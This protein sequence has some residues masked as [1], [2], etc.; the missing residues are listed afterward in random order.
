MNTKA[1]LFSFLLPGLMFGAED[2]TD[3][4]NVALQTILQRLTALEDQ[5]RQLLEQVQALRQEMAA[6]RSAP[7][8]ATGAE[9][10]ALP[11]SVEERVDVA[12]RRIE[13]QS[14]T[15]VE[16]AH[17]LP[18]SLTGMLLFNLFSNSRPNYDPTYPYTPTGPSS[19]GGTLRQTTIGLQ[20][21]G[22]SLP[23]GGNVR[24]DLVMDFFDPEREGFLRIR[25][26]DLSFNWTNRSFSVGQYSPLI[27]PYQPSSFAEVG[28]PPLAGSGNLWLWL[29]Q[30]RYEE[31]L[32]FGTADGITGQLAVLETQ[33]TYGQPWTSSDNGLEQN[34]PAIEGRA[35]YW[36][37]FDD[38]RRFELGSGFHVSTTH[39]LEASVPSRVYSI[40]WLAIPWSKLR[41]SGTLFRGQ[42]FSNLG[43]LPP[44]FTV[45][46]SYRNLVEPIHGRGGWAQLSSP[47]TS[48]LTL[49]IFGGVQDNQASDSTYGGIIRNFTYAGNLMYRISPNVI[50]SFEA[51]QARTLLMSQPEQVR[52]RYDLAFAY[53]F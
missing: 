2:K 38:E 46:D 25:T 49:N 24:G 16:T 4:Q 22:G 13:E 30:A 41:L 39:V 52:N 8:P 11:P 1:L 48:R 31:R 35:V 15:K 6:S 43:G 33:E 9:A 47:I 50:V 17:K 18:V 51:L 23:G 3:P 20:F 19:S 14:Q 53:L 12:E 26:A 44:G 36:H 10:A 42:N 37:K 7:P 28:I 32:H 40:D 5:N 45:V 21:Q 34:R 29:P 27:S